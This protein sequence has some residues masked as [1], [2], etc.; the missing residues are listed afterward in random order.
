MTLEDDIREIN[1][2]AQLIQKS[3]MAEVFEN[4]DNDTL[5][6]RTN[7]SSIDFNSNLT[8]FELS[9]CLIM[10]ELDRK[11]LQRTTL[12]RQKKRLSTSLKGLGRSQK[13]Q[14]FAGERNHQ[15][16]T[17]FLDGFLGMFKKKIE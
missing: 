10:D 15:A 1:E 7:M 4:L 3:P 12:P 6:P 8:E 11:G 9:A 17:G 5:D 16:K 2:E 14:I 13:T